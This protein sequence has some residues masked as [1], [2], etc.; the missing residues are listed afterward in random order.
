MSRATHVATAVHRLLLDRQAEIDADHDLESV[1]IVVMLPVKPGAPYKAT[2][3]RISKTD[4]TAGE[5]R[6]LPS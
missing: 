4:F 1:Q 6:G 3:R 2:L 5:L